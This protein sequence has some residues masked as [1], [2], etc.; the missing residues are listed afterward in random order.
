MNKKPNFYL[1]TETRICKDRLKLA[2]IDE[3]VTYKELSN[4][5][6]RNIQEYRNPLNSA[7]HALRRD[8][9]RDFS[10]VTGLGVKRLSDEEVVLSADFAREILRLMRCVDDFDALPIALQKKHNAEVS[11]MQAMRHFTKESSVRKIQEKIGGDVK[12]YLPTE[13]TMALFT[14]KVTKDK[15]QKALFQALDQDDEMTD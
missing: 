7:R 9:G 15:I 13:S 11:A 8:Y 6:G 4:L 2:E 1:S 14:P 10:C 12:R 5:I 3:V